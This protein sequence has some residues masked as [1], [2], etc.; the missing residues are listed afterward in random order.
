VFAKPVQ[1]KRR[2]GNLAVDSDEDDEEDDKEGWTDEEA[3]FGAGARCRRR[4]RANESG[5]GGG[6]GGGGRQEATGI[7][8]FD[9]EEQAA[10][11]WHGDLADAGGHAARFGGAVQRLQ[12]R[13]GRLRREERGGAAGERSG[14]SS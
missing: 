11:A 4:A 1:R 3:D 12:L 13:R 10:R 14:R 8:I 9:D 5:G 2:G 6:G 7:G